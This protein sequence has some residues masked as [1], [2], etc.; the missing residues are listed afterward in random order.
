MKKRILGL[1]LTMIT[2][3]SF[4]ACGASST[5]SSSDNVVAEE[6]IEEVNVEEENNYCPDGE[7]EFGLR[8]LES[9]MTCEKCGYTEGEPIQMSVALMEAPEGDSDYQILPVGYVTHVWTDEDVATNTITVY[10]KKGNQKSQNIFKY[11]GESAG[12]G[13]WYYASGDDY[14]T[15]AVG[16]DVCGAPETYAIINADGKLVRQLAENEELSS[17]EPDSNGNPIFVIRNKETDEYHF[18]DGRNG[19]DEAKVDKFK[20]LALETLESDEWDSAVESR[21]ADYYMVKKSNG[22]EQAEWGFIDKDMNL[23]KLYCDVSDFNAAGY[24]LASDDRESYYIIDKDFNVVSEACIKA[25][26]AYYYPYG[27]FFVIREGKDPNTLG[28]SSIVTVE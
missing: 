25:N 1:I 21:N 6:S 11:D 8:T 10:D 4:V 20:F 12:W 7:H 9:A 23:L 22:D 5:D 28:K 26:S 16:L 14:Y 18:I 24:A 19:V 13:C 3:M 17:I 27:D 2:T 15:L